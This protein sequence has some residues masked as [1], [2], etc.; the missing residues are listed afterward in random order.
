MGLFIGLK[1]NKSPISLTGVAISMSHEPDSAARAKKYF[2]ECKAYF[3]LSWD[4]KHDEF[5]ITNK[6]HCGAYNNPVKEVREAMYYMARKEAIIL[7]PC[8]TGK[9]FYGLLE[10]VKNG[11]I[12][13]GENIIFIHTGGIAGINGPVH[14]KAMEE[15]LK[16][17]I[18]I[19]KPNK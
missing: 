13:K 6:Y 15:E 10:M 7:D 11:E 14:R 4:A 5:D 12:K 9:A 19:K 17:G 18:I 2:D 16:D 3:N 1:D 8:Y